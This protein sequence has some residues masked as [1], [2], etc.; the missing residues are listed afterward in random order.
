MI[1]TGKWM[2]N[3]ISFAVACP[4]TIRK[5]SLNGGIK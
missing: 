4:I 1:N 5:H 3:L 2:T